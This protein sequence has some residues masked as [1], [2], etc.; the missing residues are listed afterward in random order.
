MTSQWQISD[1]VGR[2]PSSPAAT[3]P[4]P[5]YAGSKDDVRG[6]VGLAVESMKRHT[7]SEGWEIFA[8]L[9]H[10]GYVLH[11]LDIGPSITDVREI[12]SREDPSTV[13]LQDKREWMGLTADRSRDP[14]MRFRKVHE[15]G[16]RSD[17]FKATILKDAQNDRALH[18]ESATEAGVHCWILYYHPR[19]VV[20]LSPFVRPEHLIRTYHTVDAAQVP[21]YTV[22]GRKGC[23]LSGALSGAY[24]L[25]QRLA[26][27]A[28][29]L[30][31]TTVLKHP[32]YGASGSHTPQ[33][34]KLLSTYLCSICTTSRF[35]YSLKKL[36]ESVACGCV[37]VT[38][39]PADDVLPKI[40][41]ALVRVH[42]DATVDEVAEVVSHA[43]KTYDPDRQRY[44]AMKALEWYD[45][46]ASGLR[47]AADIERM[48]KEYH[49]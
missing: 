20:H 48:R 7:T 18:V 8:G 16:S 30:P 44:W 10:A 37:V 42:H 43:L 45:W 19:I 21:G 29:L 27:R 17:V 12:L 32:G 35:G 34:L 47:L 49:P 1:V 13:V 31:E 22:A 2:L 41:P 24:P 25:R 9:Q 14:K 3:I 15:L 11:G 6:R 39:L 33:Y 28:H 46:R 5:S 26:S 23:L 4:A 36:I 40:D 38:D